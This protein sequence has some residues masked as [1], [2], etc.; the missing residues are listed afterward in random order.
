MLY[1]RQNNDLED[2]YI[3]LAVKLGGFRRKHWVTIYSCMFH[4][5]IKSKNKWND[6]LLNNNNNKNTSIPSLLVVWS[7]PC[8]TWISHGSI[9]SWLS[10]LLL[11][12]V[13]I[14]R[15]L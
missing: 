1:E 4:A 3:A 9:S 11:D 14:I 10:L 5:Y 13:S 15:L 7:Y 6:I 12:H 2:K 8:L